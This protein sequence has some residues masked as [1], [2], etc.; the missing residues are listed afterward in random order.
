MM[1]NGVR[2]VPVVSAAGDLI[3][4]ITLDDM[5]RQLPGPLAQLAE[6]TDRGRQHEIRMRA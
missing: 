4:I 2:R 5:L 6:L 3:G 1:P